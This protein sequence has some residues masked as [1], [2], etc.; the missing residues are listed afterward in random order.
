MRSI[1][2]VCEQPEIK[3]DAKRVLLDNFY[4]PIKLILAAT[5]LNILQLIIKRKAGLA[6]R[7]A[8]AIG[9]LLL[10]VDVENIADGRDHSRRAASASLLERSQLIDCNGTLLDLKAHISGQSTQTL[11]GD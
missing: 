9:N 3:P 7:L 4:C 8:I 10:G 5:I 6:D 11:V 1:L 2:D